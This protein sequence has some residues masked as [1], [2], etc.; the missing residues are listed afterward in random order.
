M[1]ANCDCGSLRTIGYED[2]LNV[3]FNEIL[4]DYP[5]REEYL[6]EI[7]LPFLKDCCPKG[8]KVIPVFAD[9]NVGRKKKGNNERIAEANN[10]RMKII[11]AES[12]SDPRYKYVVPDF[13]FVPEEYSYV[14]PVKPLIMVE[15]KAPD[16]K[17]QSD[18]KYIYKDIIK[19]IKLNKNEISDEI[20]A[21]GMVI[22]TD[23]I[24]WAFL[25]KQEGEIVES[26]DYP[27]IRL[28]DY[29]E[30]QKYTNPDTKRVNPLLNEI[31]L[32]SREN[33]EGESNWDTLKRQIKK[34]LKEQVKK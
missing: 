34:V 15:T 14:N 25:V 13:I 27:T 5:S 22:Y 32:F 30:E 29:Q 9:R 2:Y 23:C 17:K 3:L 12:K 20:E 21:C 26:E 18:Q 33:K 4:L 24:S 6:G 31:S 11:C 1:I 10:V 19:T 7:I 28:V 16:I 8:I